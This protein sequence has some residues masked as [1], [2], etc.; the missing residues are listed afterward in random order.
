M[1]RVFMVSGAFVLSFVGFNVPNQNSKS[2][3]FQ[4]EA[5]TL[6]KPGTPPYIPWYTINEARP[7][8]LTAQS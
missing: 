7:M 4:T 2:G 6:T 1:S 3:A 5:R 8:S